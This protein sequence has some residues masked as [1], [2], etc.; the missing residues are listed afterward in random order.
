MNQFNLKF[1]E[2]SLSAY[3]SD[4]PML[5]ALESMPITY[6]GENPKEISSF[7]KAY[8]VTALSDLTTQALRAIDLEGLKNSE[9]G[10]VLMFDNPVK[11]S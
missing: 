2:Q 7:V 9:S 4:Y 1:S 5:S 3:G 11:L 6:E 10:D 8:L